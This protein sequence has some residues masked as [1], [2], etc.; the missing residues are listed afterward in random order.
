MV[1][2]TN[3]TVANTV[4]EDLKKANW[5]LLNTTGI[6]AV[7]EKE[8]RYEQNKILVNGG[9]LIMC[10]FGIIQFDFFNY[11]YPMTILLL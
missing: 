2:P 1:A 11:S 4:F 10:A 7:L 8:T 9:I 3:E 5:T 6:G